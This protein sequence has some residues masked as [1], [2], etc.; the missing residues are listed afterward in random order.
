MVL[1]LGRVDVVA[2]VAVHK[3][4]PPVLHGTRGVGCVE[5]TEVEAQ[6]EQRAQADHRHQ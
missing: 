2:V 6:A 1:L 4:V 5:E 3:A